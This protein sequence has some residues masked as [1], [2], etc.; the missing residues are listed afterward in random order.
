[1][2]FLL[3]T[4][5]WQVGQICDSEATFFDGQWITNELFVYLA[6]IEKEGQTAYSLRILD[7]TR[8]EYQ[9]IFQS[10]PGYGI[11]L[12]GWTNFEFD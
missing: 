8:W 4:S 2:G 10:E 7:V 3:D 9:E 12:F 6:L 11:N 5:A 1:M